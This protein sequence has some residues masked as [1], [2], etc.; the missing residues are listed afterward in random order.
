MPTARALAAASDAS[1]GEEEEEEE[2]EEVVVVVEEE[3]EEEDCSSLLSGKSCSWKW[4]HR[5]LDPCESF[6]HRLTNSV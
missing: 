2:E 6:V 4:R 1:V 3:E 5:G